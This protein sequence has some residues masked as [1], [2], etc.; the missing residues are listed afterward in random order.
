MPHKP[1]IYIFPAPLKVKFQTGDL[2]FENK[3]KATFSKSLPFFLAC[4]ELWGNRPDCLAVALWAC[5]LFA[6][7]LL[8]SVFGV[9]CVGMHDGGRRSQCCICYSHLCDVSRGYFLIPKDINFV[10]KKPAICHLQFVGDD[11][12]FESALARR[13]LKDFGPVAIR[14]F[15]ANIGRSTKASLANL[16]HF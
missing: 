7:D 8:A 15:Q 4:L 5:A 3:Q 11:P 6:F 12:A 9:L 2:I 14:Q 10:R 13:H 1:K 16:E